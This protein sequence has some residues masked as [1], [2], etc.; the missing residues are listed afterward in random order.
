MKKCET[1]NPLIKSL[2]LNWAA[3]MVNVDEIATLKKVRKVLG[4]IMKNDMKCVSLLCNRSSDNFSTV[5]PT[6]LLQFSRSS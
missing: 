6:I 4:K 2:W 3:E 5:C 1:K